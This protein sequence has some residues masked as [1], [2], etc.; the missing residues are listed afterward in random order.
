LYF[1]L[2]ALYFATILFAENDM[3]KTNFENLQVY[4]LAEKLADDVWTIAIKWEFFARDTVGKQLVRAVDS[5]EANIAEGTGRGSFNDNRRFV[6]IARGSLYETRH[7][8]RRAY[9]RH[10]LTDEQ[11]NTL[12]PIIDELTPKLN[13]YFRSI[14]NAVNKQNTRDI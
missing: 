2:G 7:W 13:A 12:K 8:L 5:I 10:L 6:K 9:H 3:T 11:V 14:N 4:Q 1:V